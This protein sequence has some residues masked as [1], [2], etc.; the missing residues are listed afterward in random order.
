MVSFLVNTL[1]IMHCI[2]GYANPMRLGPRNQHILQ[3]NQVSDKGSS[4]YFKDMTFYFQEW[5]IFLVPKKMGSLLIRFWE[6]THP[7]PPSQHFAL[8]LRGEGVRQFS[9]NVY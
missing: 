5:S 1:S 8:S 3:K 9:R 2:F 6:T 7:P 4:L